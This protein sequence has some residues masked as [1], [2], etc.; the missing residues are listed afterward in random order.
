[1]YLVVPS[2]LLQALSFSFVKSDQRPRRF[3]RVGLGLRGIALVASLA[4]GVILFT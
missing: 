3:T 4:A 1:M 2:A